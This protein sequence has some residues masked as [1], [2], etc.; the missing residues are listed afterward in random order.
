MYQLCLDLRGFYLKVIQLERFSLAAPSPPC[1]QLQMDWVL[2]A[3]GHVHVS[4]V[5]AAYIGA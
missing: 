2:E 3:T 4:C 1:H 5:Q